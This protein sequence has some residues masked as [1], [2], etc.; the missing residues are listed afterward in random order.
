VA[1]GARRGG[2]AVRRTSSS[3]QLHR[4]YLQ[5]VGSLLVVL[6]LVSVVV[7]IESSR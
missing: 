6:V 4:Y 7:L 1:R 3:G 5:L 2:R